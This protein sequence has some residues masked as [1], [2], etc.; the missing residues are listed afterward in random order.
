MTPDALEARL[1]AFAR[2][3]GEWSNARAGRTP[4]EFTAWFWVE[5]D[6]ILIEAGARHEATA[7]ERIRD[8]ADTA[9]DAGLFGRDGYEHVPF[10]E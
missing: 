5:A 3:I 6:E 4:A 10:P 9:L 7:Q 8:L 1:R 2:E